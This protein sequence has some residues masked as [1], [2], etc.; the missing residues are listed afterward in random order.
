M[1]DIK[2][3]LNRKIIIMKLINILY[4]FLLIG[5]VVYISSCSKDEKAVL[6][7][8]YSQDPDC[9]CQENP[10]NPLCNITCTF[11]TNP[12]CFCMQNPDDAQCCSF[13]YD[14]ICYCAEN[15]TDIL[16]DNSGPS[17]GFFTFFD[18]EDQPELDSIFDTG[19]IPD[20]PDGWQESAKATPN[21]GSGDAAQGEYYFINEIEVINAGWAWT[22]NLYKDTPGLDLSSLSEPTLNFWVRSSNAKPT[23]LE[24]AFVDASGESGYH[25]GGVYAEING[26][27]QQFSINI[28]KINQNEEWKWGDGIDPATISLLKFGFNAEAQEQGDIYE[29]HI[30]DVYISDGAES[31]AIEYPMIMEPGDF[32]VYFDFED[33]PEVDSIFSTGYIPDNP[34]GWQENGKATASLGSGDAAQ[35]DFYFINEIEVINAGWAWTSNL[36]DDMS[37]DAS[38]LSSPHFNFWARTSNAKPA[39]FEIALS[40]D[41]GESGWHPGGV[42]GEINGNW[43]QFS[44]N[45]NE[46]NALGDWKWGDGIDVATLSFMKFGFNTEAQEQGDIY[47]VHLDVISLTDG[48]P[49]GAITY[50]KTAPPAYTRA[51]TAFDFEDTSIPIDSIFVS[52]Y[53]PDNPDGWQENAKPTANY[54]NGDAAEGDGFLSVEIEVI[55]EGWTWTGNLADDTMNDFS[56]LVD[57]CINFWA[58]T[59]D[60][61][62]QLFEIAFADS[63][64]ESGWHPGG[65]YEDIN[66][67]WKQFS[68]QL[69]QIEE[70]KWGQGP[71][72]ADFQLLK[73]GFNANGHPQGDIYEVHVDDIHFSDG[74]PMGAIVL[75]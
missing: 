19:Y 18:F 74:S 17:S 29:I 67:D 33:Q 10:D 54:M 22:S 6:G 40:D 9:F 52:G 25:P 56:G 55:N 51:Y 42:Y 15:P 59:G 7:C 23:L 11:E 12:D 46:V 61:S 4:F 68:I 66:G 65:N 1:L 13:E 27:W 63:N 16:C 28:A 60:G 39:L 26:D 36:F 72:W 43:Q 64:G 14:P 57:P 47:E 69:S 48:A 37:I 45:I 8:T 44:I 62:T 20:N 35:G 58:R 34:D 3:L 31:G 41:S 21:L 49:S 2:I 30:D 32:H 50:P 5:S 38:G 24:I 70:W 75:K 71:D 73:F 53:I